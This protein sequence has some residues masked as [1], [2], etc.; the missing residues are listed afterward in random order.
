M[1]LKNLLVKS[2]I[3]SS[4]GIAVCVTSVSSDTFGNGKY[5]ITDRE[6]I[7]SIE[8]PTPYVYS[9]YEK[10]GEFLLYNNSTVNIYDEPSTSSKVAGKV[11]P[12]VLTGKR[13]IGDWFLINSSK[14]D[15]WVYW[16]DDVE[17]REIESMVDTKIEIRESS[18]LHI[19]PFST[20]KRDSKL[21]AGTY[22]VIKKSGDWYLTEQ[23]WV[24]TYLASFVG[25]RPD[26]TVS[27]IN[28]I[29]ILKKITE[30]NDF[31]RPGNTLKPL[32]ITIHNAA[33]TSVGADAEA[34]ANL[35]YNNSISAVDYVSWHFSVDD[36][37]IY[38]S[39]PLN[40][41]AWH[42]G[43]GDFGPGNRSSIAI[44]ICENSDGDY[45]KAESNAAYLTAQLLHD[46]SLP[47]S[48]VK[49]HKDFSGKNCPARILGK[50]DGWNKFISK[51]QIAY[52]DLKDDVQPPEPPPV[53]KTAYLDIGLFVGES[54]VNNAYN[55]LKRDNNWYMSIKNTG[56]SDSVYKLVT[57]GFK[58]KDAVIVALEKLKSSTGWWCS[59]EP[60]PKQPDYYRIYTGGFIGLTEAQNALAKLKSL[61]GWW[62]TY[63]DTGRYEY[64]Y[65]IYTGG[66]KEEYALESSKLVKERY[67]WYNVIRY[68]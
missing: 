3:L 24:N 52:D 21:S 61:T 22:N 59:Y 36:G 49:A 45:E 2:A 62:V 16:G 25:V 34:H 42:A 15:K 10:D 6:H 35:Q 40:E 4:L 17:L 55:I 12:Q 51:V 54:A 66:M 43:D 20:Y 5:H 50:S 44:E 67:G 58:G 64:K 57:G 46:Y 65:W 8:T 33:N 9:N 28:E 18:Y 11:A 60:V 7:Q 56:D 37:E 14:G 39:I 63:S 27:S 23:G 13:R 30:F 19:K 47:I 48:A 68:K 1:G 31:V 32:Y 29:P 38:Q 53:P 26:L 41:V